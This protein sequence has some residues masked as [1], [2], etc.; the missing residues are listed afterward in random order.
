M[1]YRNWHRQLYQAKL[2]IKSKRE[3]KKLPI[4]KDRLKEDTTTKTYIQRILEGIFQTKKKNKCNQ[5]A[6]GNKY[7][8][9]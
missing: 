1:K 5:E 9:K 7:T 6:V 8:I 2:S 4:I 3:I